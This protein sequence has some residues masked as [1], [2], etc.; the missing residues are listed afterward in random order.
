M[1]RS[2]M[3]DFSRERVF[4]QRPAAAGQSTTV[5]GCSAVNLT[6]VPSF[7]LL[8]MTDDDAGWDDIAVSAS[9]RQRLRGFLRLGYLPPMVIYGPLGVGKTLLARHLASKFNYRMVECDATD[10]SL[11]Q[12]GEIQ[13]DLRLRVRGPRVPVVVFIDEI[14][15]FLKRQ[16][17]WLLGYVESGEFTFIGATTYNVHR[18]LNQA[19]LSRCHW[20]KMEPPSPSMMVAAVTAT[21]SATGTAAFAVSQSGKVRIAQAANHDYRRANKLVALLY[22]TYGDRMV[23]DAEVATVVGLGPKLTSTDRNWLFRRVEGCLEGIVAGGDRSR[24]W[25]LN[26]IDILVDLGA[27]EDTA[28]WL[29]AYGAAHASDDTFVSVVRS[30]KAITA[31]ADAGQILRHGFLLLHGARGRPQA[32]RVRLS[33]LDLAHAVVDRRGNRARQPPK[34]TYDA[35]VVSRLVRRC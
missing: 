34:I 23:S 4:S 25:G 10:T 11:A 27:V 26:Y 7:P 33:D 29:M 8:P 35:K 17:D 30:L 31:G 3:G 21:V 28:K 12:L 18:R 19:L 9:D 2:W 5:F 13:R 14:H 15:R 32:R 24:Q 22:H 1:G 20:V 6:T 16:Q